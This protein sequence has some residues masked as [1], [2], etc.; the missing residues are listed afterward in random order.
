MLDVSIE[1]LDEIDFLELQSE[2]SQTN[3]A[4]RL[5]LNETLNNY[6]D[7]GP[8]LTTASKE[9]TTTLKEVSQLSR[10]LNSLVRSDS[11]F[12]F[13]FSNT[14]RDVSLMSKSL[15]RLADLLERNPQAFLIGK[16]NN[17]R[18]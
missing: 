2:W 8:E 14:M 11:D 12:T 15:K 16:P 17:S 18:E 7:L 9:V 3:D 5:F 4:I 6:S 10:S 13:Q 1:R